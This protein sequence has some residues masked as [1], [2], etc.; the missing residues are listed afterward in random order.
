[1]D[2]RRLA[3]AIAVSAAAVAPA[4]AD[5]YTWIDE[6][7]RLN[8]SNLDPPPGVTVTHV[9]RTL[10]QKPLPPAPAGDEAIA[11]LRDRVAALQDEI[12]RR[13][14]VPRVVYMAPPDEPPDVAGPAYDVA[15]AYPLAPIQQWISVYGTAPPPASDGCDPSWWGCAYGWAP[16][17]AGVIVVPAAPHRGIPRPSHRR[18]PHPGMPVAAP[19]PPSVGPVPPPFLPPSLRVAMTAMPNAPAL[20]S[21]PVRPVPPSQRVAFTPPHR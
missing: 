10:P 16:G 15:A 11:A 18:P 1:M 5:I 8:V 14:G 13:D 6:S 21:P 17:Y 3:A 4:H 19:R 7:G 20:P 12:A 2:A 9:D